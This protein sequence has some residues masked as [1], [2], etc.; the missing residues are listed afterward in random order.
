MDTIQ[1]GAW[2]ACAGI[3]MGRSV[4]ETIAVAIV[5]GSPDLLSQ[6]WRWIKGPDDWRAYLYLHDPVVS[7]A[8][9]AITLLLYGFTFYLPIPLAGAAYCLHTTMDIPVHKLNRRWW[10]LNEMFWAECLGWVLILTFL[11]VWYL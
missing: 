7:G 4:K 9:F 11:G 2:G 1:H 8:F 3:A 5:G 10:K 6:F